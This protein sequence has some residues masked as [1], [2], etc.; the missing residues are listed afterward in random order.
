MTDQSIQT[1]DEHMKSP[2]WA[3]HGAID[4]FGN[5]A[6]A[7][8]GKSQSPTFAACVFCCQH[9]KARIKECWYG[10]DEFGEWGLSAVCNCCGRKLEFDMHALGSR[11]EVVR[12]CDA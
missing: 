4:Q 2:S 12:L 10:N 7:A 9:T 6:C 5:V 8:C 11:Y 3:L 1:L